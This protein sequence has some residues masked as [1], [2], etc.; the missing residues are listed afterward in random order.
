MRLP[1]CGFLLYMARVR[2]QSLISYLS[3]FGHKLRHLP[4]KS[5]FKVLASATPDEVVRGLTAKR[6]L[7][8]IRAVT[9]RQE[10]P[11]L[12]ASSCHRH[13]SNREDISST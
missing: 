13:F 3:V 6:I 11:N 2:S 9:S 7:G 10:I 4:T 12:P 1:N 5:S 8:P